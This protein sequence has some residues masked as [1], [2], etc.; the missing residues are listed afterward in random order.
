MSVK[1]KRFLK[2]KVSLPSTKTL[3]SL[4]NNNFTYYPGT[5]V[6]FLKILQQRDCAKLEIGWGWFGRVVS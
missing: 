6:I 3:K 2:A 1:E 4:T 5:T